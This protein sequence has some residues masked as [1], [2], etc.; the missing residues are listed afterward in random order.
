[1]DGEHWLL[2]SRPAAPLA[3][4]CAAVVSAGAQR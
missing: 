2:E 4:M 3:L 1:M